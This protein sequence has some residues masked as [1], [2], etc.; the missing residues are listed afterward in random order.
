MKSPQGGIFDFCLEE[1][2]LLKNNTFI[3]SGL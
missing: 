2:V 3:N 1:K